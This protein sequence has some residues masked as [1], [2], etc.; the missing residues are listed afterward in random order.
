MTGS[1][2]IEFLALLPMVQRYQPQ[3]GRVIV[4]LITLVPLAQKGESARLRG[5]PFVPKVE[6]T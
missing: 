5:Y 6:K 1:R 2:H 3:I 4:T